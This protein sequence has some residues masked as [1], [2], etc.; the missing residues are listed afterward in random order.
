M[1]SLNAP[2]QTDPRGARSSRPES[3][4]RAKGLGKYRDDPRMSYGLWDPP[5][6]NLAGPDASGI[7]LT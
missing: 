6:P 3:T 4:V 1:S 5:I 2:I 7:A